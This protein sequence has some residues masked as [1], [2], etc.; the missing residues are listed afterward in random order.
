LQSFALMRSIVEHRIRARVWL[1]LATLAGGGAVYVN[2]AMQ[3]REAVRRGRE[4]RVETTA[5]PPSR[6]GGPITTTPYVP[7]PEPYV[8]PE[9]TEEPAPRAA[10]PEDAG[11][12]GPLARAE[13][14]AGAAAVAEDAAVAV[15]AEDAAVVAAAEDTGVADA[16]PEGGV[17]LAAVLADAGIAYDPNVPYVTPVFGVPLEPG[18]VAAAQGQQLPQ[19]VGAGGTAE[20][21]TVTMAGG[22]SSPGL[23][24]AGGTAAEPSAS[25]AGGTSQG[26]VGAGGTVAVP[27]ADMAGGTSIGAAGAGGTTVGNAGAVSP[28]GQQPI[29]PFVPSLTG[30][31]FAPQ[32]NPFMNP[33]V[34]FGVAPGFNGF[35]GVPFFFFV[36]PL[37]AFGAVPV[38]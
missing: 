33:A 18:A 19:P 2:D 34:P 35:V 3:E 27:S 14:D 22:T 11:D 5:T 10:E 29:N 24:G 36:P 32:V 28:F 7:P 1:V 8:P 20:T 23:V 12:A 15:A 31:P 13:E 37:G 6:A 4:A 17:D 16:A 30:T 26:I 25:M 9:A 38:Q 21:P